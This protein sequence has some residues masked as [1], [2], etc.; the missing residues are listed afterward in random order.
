[1]PRRPAGSALLAPSTRPAALYSG[2]PTSPTCRRL[3]LDAGLTPSPIA[4]GLCEFGPH[5]PI[6]ASP[7]PLPAVEIG[8]AG[9]RA[10]IGARQQAARGP[11]RVVSARARPVGR[12]A[13]RARQRGRRPCHRSCLCKLSRRRPRELDAERLCRR[14]S[15]RSRRALALSALL[16]C[17]LPPA[18][19]LLSHPPKL[20]AINKSVSDLTGVLVPLTFT[21]GSRKLTETG[22][23]EIHSQ[24]EAERVEN[25][26]FR[27][28]DI[29]VALGGL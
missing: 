2:P 4:L 28:A 20:S 13:Y 12:R 8:I 22:N 25:E 3:R 16:A 24:D 7:C 17:L 26:R 21:H 19:P 5:F 10:R 1:M 14:H 9:T 15:V 27:A 29:E 11:H 18:T 6:F 23:G